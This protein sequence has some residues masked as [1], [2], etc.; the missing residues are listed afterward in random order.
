MAFAIGMLLRPFALLAILGGLLCVRFAVA[1]WWPDGRLKR[2]LLLRVD[3][4][5]QREAARRAYPR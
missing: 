1:R 2:L 4:A 5:G 3:Y